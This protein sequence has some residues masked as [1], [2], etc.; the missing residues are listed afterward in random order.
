MSN[1]LAGEQ[2]QFHSGAEAVCFLSSRGFETTNYG[3]GDEPR[4]MRDAAGRVALIHDR[5]LLEWE[6]EYLP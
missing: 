1:L 2:T 6:I 5:A 3:E 4:E